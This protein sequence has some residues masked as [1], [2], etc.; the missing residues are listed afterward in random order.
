M[1]PTYSFHKIKGH[2]L[3]QSLSNENKEFQRKEKTIE[4]TFWVYENNI[5][6]YINKLSLIEIKKLIWKFTILSKF[7]KYLYI[8]VYFSLENYFLEKLLSFVLGKL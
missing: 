2:S 5:N 6:Q 1:K 4:E 8:D 3:L 7:N